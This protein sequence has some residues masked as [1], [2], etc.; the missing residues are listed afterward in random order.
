MEELLVFQS[1]TDK[2]QALRTAATLENHHVFVAIEEN[3]MPLDSNFLGQ[4]FSNPYVLKI[5]ANEFIRADEILMEHT[6]V[7]I[8]EV[9]KDYM[10]LSFTSEELIEV[11]KHR[12]DWGIYNYKL[13]G[14]LLQQ[15][16]VPVTQHEITAAREQT[17]AEAA[18]PKSYDTFWLI[19]GY[20]M[21]LFAGYVVYT[22]IN[23]VIFTFPALFALV[24]GARLFL[25]RK[26]LSD[27][28]R[29]PAYR[30]SSRIHGVF[31]FTIALVLFVFRCW[32][33][34]HSY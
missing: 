28:T 5:P 13:A 25:S 18:Q 22:E 8:N 26:T 3:L 1:F 24:V 6:V 31:I 7:D 16:N 29:I 32:N 34:A 21:A 10:L 9:D 14:I 33:E 15:R 12:D 11:M 30:F 19:F 17:F 20:I 27:G 23:T 4:Q 2:E